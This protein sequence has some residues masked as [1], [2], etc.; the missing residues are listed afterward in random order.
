[1]SSD[2][3]PHPLD[4]TIISLIRDYER[5]KYNHPEQLESSQLQIV[6]FLKNKLV[7]VNDSNDPFTDL[8][9]PG[10]WAGFCKETW[11]LERSSPPHTF[12]ISDTE[13]YKLLYSF[14]DSVVNINMFETIILRYSKDIEN[15]KILAYL[16]EIVT[17]AEQ[18]GLHLAFLPFSTPDGM[19]VFV[20]SH[21]L[22]YNLIWVDF[23][24]N[25]CSDSEFTAELYRYGPLLQLSPQFDNDKIAW[26]YPRQLTDLSEST[27]VDSDLPVVE[28][29]SKY[30][31]KAMNL[32]L[33]LDNSPIIGYK[34]KIDPEIYNQVQH[35]YL[36]VQ[37]FRTISPQAA[38]SLECDIYNYYIY[39]DVKDPLPLRDNKLN[40]FYED[41]HNLKALNDNFSY[42]T[43]VIF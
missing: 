21:K 23:M 34:N 35:F 11:E 8:T 30:N 12:I 38:Q 14:D 16:D 41:L 6:N 2:S 42:G 25:L 13:N 3:S 40:L 1:M 28:F 39:H 19:L 32:V 5:I 22:Q 29:Y 18:S 20:L 37:Y 33:L 24:L 43:T 31:D 17:F 7:A 26:I 9:E 36:L 27:V 10:C 15:G 4:S